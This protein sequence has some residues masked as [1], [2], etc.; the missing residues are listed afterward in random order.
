MRRN[1]VFTLAASLTVVTTLACGAATTAVAPST[2]VSV[3][4]TPSAEATSNT[5][6]TIDAAVAAT[7]TAQA[8]L[9]AT[10]DTIVQATMAAAQA[11]ATAAPTS[12]P[13][14]EYVNMTEEELAALIEQSV[15]EAT[16]ATQES[17]DATVEA[18]A[19]GTVTPEEVDELEAYLAETEELIAY[20]EELID[21]YYGLYGELDTE[22]LE[23][24]AIE[25]D[26]TLL[27][28]EAA[29]IEA[30]LIAV[31][32]TLKQGLVLAEETIT[33]LEAAAQACAVQAAAIQAQAQSW[34]QALQ[35]ELETR[36]AN[37]LAV[38][39]NAVA[40]N[41]AGAILSAFDYVDAVRIALED[42]SLSLTELEVIAQLG[43]NASA[44]LQAHGGPQLQQLAGSINDITAQL[45]SG[46]VPQARVNL[47]NLE[48]T[49]G[50]RPS[51]P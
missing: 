21:A 51:R 19:D 44:G 27:A 2:Q 14:A 18:A 45:A 11:T 4:T 30:A 22:T 37:A 29:A 34:Q 6:A 20:T 47:G 16:A 24:I 32:M 9:Q 23:L 15:A 10:V 46:Q 42:N 35:S 28:E 41:R 49:L 3:A 50:T 17:A 5:Q 8:G 38:Q 25:D 36:V 43:A 12:T 26:L 33:E 40:P 1:T 39:P 48:A 13:A 7:G 31:D